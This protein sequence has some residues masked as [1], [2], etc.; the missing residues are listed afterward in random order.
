VLL[1]IQRENYISI[2]HSRINIT[3]GLSAIQWCEIIPWCRTCSQHSN[4]TVHVVCQSEGLSCFEATFDYT[5][6]SEREGGGPYSQIMVW[7]SLPQSCIAKGLARVCLC[8]RACVYFKQRRVGVRVRVLMYALPSVCIHIVTWI[9]CETWA[10]SPTTGLIIQGALAENS[11]GGSV[12]PPCLPPFAGMVGG[13]ISK[14]ENHT[15]F[16]W[17]VHLNRGN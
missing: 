13:G 9:N 4:N 3:T 14:G 7:D 5:A 6:D 16:L 15:C 17:Y 12:R 10:G 2:V 1:L 8:A 11:P